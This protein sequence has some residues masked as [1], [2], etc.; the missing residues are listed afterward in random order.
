[1]DFDPV[2]AKAAGGQPF[3]MSGKVAALFPSRFV[4]SEIGTIP[5]AWESCKWGDISTLEYGKSLRSHG[6]A[7]GEVRVYGT[8]GPI[9][10]H[11][12]ALCNTAGIVIGRKGAYRGVH[13]SPAPFF[14]IDTAF[15]L[16]PRREFEILWAYYLNPAHSRARKASASPADA[17]LEHFVGFHV[18]LTFGEVNVECAVRPEIFGSPVIIGG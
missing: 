7:I 17:G 9:G 18:N 2:V 15:Y 3:G 13:Y 5:A 8:N 6:D 14:V 4:D 1:V 12:E 11:T 10:W 16:K